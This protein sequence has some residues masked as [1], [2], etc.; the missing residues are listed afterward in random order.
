MIVPDS[1]V[2]PMRVAT[3]ANWI[4]IG[5]LGFCI[6]TWG[7]GVFSVAKT[8]HLY[9]NRSAAG[10]RHDVVEKARGKWVQFKQVV[11]PIRP[12]AASHST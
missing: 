10:F 4:A 8:A 12:A 1:G 6:L 5:V 3:R 2:G 11:A 7:V 9:T